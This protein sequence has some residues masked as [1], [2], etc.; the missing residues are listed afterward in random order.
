[1]DVA[2]LPSKEPVLKVTT[3][4]NDANPK[5]DIFGGWLMSKM[6][7]AGAVLAVNR[8]K[9]SVATVAVENLQF[10][11]P[12]YVHDLVSFYG[13]IVKEGKSSM[14]VELE[15]YAQR[16]AQHMKQV[17]KIATATFVYVAIDKPGV[18]RDLPD[19]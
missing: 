7:I 13:L 16:L 10:I 8:A 15:V 9:G 6:D 5:G 17:V 11:N 1:M 19:S 18:K 12:L 4:P 2:E 14:T 3:M